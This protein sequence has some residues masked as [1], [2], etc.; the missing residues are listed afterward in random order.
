MKKIDKLDLARKITYV[1]SNIEITPDIPLNNLL[2]RIEDKI[3][4]IIERLDK[5]ARLQ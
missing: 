2:Q 5:N 4:E 1:V 3:N